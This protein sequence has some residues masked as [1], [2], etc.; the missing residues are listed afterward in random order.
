MA[1]KIDDGFDLEAF[2]ARPLVARLATIGPRVRPLWFI[3]EDG[4]FWWL[5]GP[6]AKLRDYLAADPRVALVVDH[7]DVETGEVKIVTA[8]GE[9]E[10]VP[11]DAGRAERKFTRYL[12]SDT[13]RW[14]PRFL[15][16]WDPA[17]RTGSDDEP[18]G[19]GRL[20]PRTLVARDRSFKVGP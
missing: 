3:W 17:F 13:S 1:W 15:S 4:A 19:F 6:W 2:L 7:T 10:I 20:V 14:D 5:T 12:G 8:L 16:S 18:D 9:A 11:W